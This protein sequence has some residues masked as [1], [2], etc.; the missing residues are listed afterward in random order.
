MKTR[1]LLAATLSAGVVA[2]HNASAAQEAAVQPQGQE[3]SLTKPLRG[4]QVYPRAAIEANGGYLVW[5]DNATDGDGDGISAVRVDSGLSGTFEPFRVNADGVGD[6]GK[7][8]V[9]LLP[10]GSAAFVWESGNSIRARVLNSAGVF[11][12]TTDIL[13]NS[14]QGTQKSNPTVVGLQDGGALV[15]W[16][17]YGQDDVNNFEGDGGYRHL[18]G[19]YAQRLS[20]AGAK[21]GAEIQINQQVRFNQRNPAVA[22]LSSGDVVAVW[23]SERGQV[24]VAEGQLTDVVDGVEVMGRYFSPSGELAGDEFILSTPRRIAATPSIAASGDGFVLTWAQADNESRELGFDIF[25]RSF[26]ATGLPTTPATRINSTQYGDQ[27]S[28]SVATAGGTEM[29]L[30]TSLGQDGSREGV[31]GQFLMNGSRIGG[32][33][34]VN[35]TT[36]SRQIYPRAVARGSDNFL[37]LWSSFVGSPRDFE[38]VAQRYAL[39]LPIAPTPVV[40]A[41]SANRLGVAWSPVGGYENVDYLVFMDG[42]AEPAVTQDFYW[43]TPATLQPASTHL[44]RLAF[45]L[46]GGTVSPLSESASGTTWGA[47]ENFDGLPD[48]WQSLY[49]SGPSGGWPGPSLDSDS[50]GMINRDEFLAGTDPTKASSIL[51][52]AVAQTPQGTV[53]SWNATPGQ[54]YQLQESGDL[55]A[56]TALGQ[57]RFARSTLDQAV[58]DPA[59]GAR[60]YRV[61]R[62]R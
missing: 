31:Y 30:W 56:W 9:A 52:T 25:A 46:P 58:V 44:F 29:I 34:R 45:R 17:S 62:L 16:S 42:T 3:Y 38:V 39:T 10:G 8:D 23:V 43:T 53:V 24:G 11:T 49:W 35:T 51:K 41:L 57:A 48:D 20:P 4:D 5:Q 28:P 50:D 32:E 19:V 47:D 37:A 1:I 15:L 27:F 60:Y 13:V 2:G 33:F 55:K 18:Q 21:I 7:P 14:H 12:T 59:P 26:N 61:I 36:A 54:V 40:S 6:Q 22:R